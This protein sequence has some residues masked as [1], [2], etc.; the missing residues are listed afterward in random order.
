MTPTTVAGVSQHLYDLD[1]ILDMVDQ[2][3]PKPNRP[4]TYKKRQP[5]G[6]V[7]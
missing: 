1:W 6:A 4:K 5:E 2:A 3:W 7:P